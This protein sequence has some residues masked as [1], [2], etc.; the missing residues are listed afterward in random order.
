MA[1]LVNDLLDLL[2]KNSLV[3]SVRIVNYD[4]TPAG[5]LE[6]KIRCRLIKSCKLQI[7]L[8][9][10]TNFRD[11]AYQLFTDHPILRWDNSPHYPNISSAPHHMHNEEGE[12]QA[13]PLSGRP[14]QDLKKV[15][16]EI[17]KWLSAHTEIL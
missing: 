13:S 11:Y 8:H 6:L 7:W 10:E 16:R 2:Q 5:K 12:V 1:A 4:E 15:L 9:E 17:E 14:L 3:K